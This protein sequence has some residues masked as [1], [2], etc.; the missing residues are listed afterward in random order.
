MIHIPPLRERREDIPLLAE[1]ILK[2]ESEGLGDSAFLLPEA[3]VK[4]LSHHWP[5]NVRELENVLKNA[6]VFCGDHKITTE[7]ITFDEVVPYESSDNLYSEN[8]L[9]LQKYVEMIEDK[10]SFWEVVHRPFIQ[11]EL[12][13][14]EVVEII[15]MGLKEAK[16]YKKLMK[17]FNAGKTYKDYKNFMK[18]IRH[19]R[20][21]S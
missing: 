20:L 16:T 11:R 13:R 8:S 19:H 12:K 14:E 4:L 21:S 18:I 7:A 17:L 10:K 2:K 3:L 1:N 9:V 5:G 15:Q 6:M